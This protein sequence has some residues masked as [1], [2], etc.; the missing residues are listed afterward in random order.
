M[1]ARNLMGK[2]FG[3]LTVIKL[4][5]RIKSDSH[6]YRSFWKCICECGNNS[7]V[8]QDALLYNSTKSCGCLAKE[9]AGSWVRTHGMTGSPTYSAWLGMKKRCYRES[10]SAFKHYGARGIIV[11]DRWR[12]SFESFL[13][14]MGECPEGLTI[15]RINVNGNY[16]PGNCCWKTSL[17]QA[18]NK[19]NTI[20]GLNG[21]SLR[22]TAMDIGI[23]YTYL[24]KLHR[25]DGIP[26]MDAIG[27]AC[28]ARSLAIPTPK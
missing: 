7:I 3:R 21:L 27:I 11:C 26:L 1:A 28:R 5:R 17:D 19:R 6:H 2:K 12:R 10:H 8:A 4:D 13:S 20:I 24:H 16:D 18:S 9:I 22:R 23:S 14:D 15:E 25:K